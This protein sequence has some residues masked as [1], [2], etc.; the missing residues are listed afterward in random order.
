MSSR[1]NRMQFLKIFALATVLT[2]FAPPPADAQEF[3]SRQIHLARTTFLQPM[4]TAGAAPQNV[5]VNSRSNPE[6]MLS[7]DGTNAHDQRL[8]NGGQT[9]S[10]EPAQPGLCVGNGFAL[11]TT[12]GGVHIFDTRGNALTGVTDL[13]TF[14]G[15]P[16]AFSITNEYGPEVTDVSC[17]SDPDTQ[18]MF[19]L[20]LTLERVGTTSELSKI[21]HLDV[22]VS[23][24]PNP[25]G[26]WNIYK[27]PAQND[28]T[29]GTPNLHCVGGPCLA[30]FP[31]IGA[32]A[33]GIYI[34][35]NAFSFE[36]GF[37]NSKLHGAQ[38]YAISKR[39]LTSGQSAINVIEFDT[40]DPN[41]LLDGNPGFSIKA[42]TSPAA[43]YAKDL[44][45]TEYFLSSLAVVKLL[46]P[47]PPRKASDKRLRIWALSNTQS[48]DSDHPV[49]TLKHTVVDVQSYTTPAWYKQKKG[50]TPLRKCL[51]DSKL[52]TPNGVGCWRV[53]GFTAQPDH[54]RRSLIL[55]SDSRMQQVVF[56]DGKLWSALNT[57]LDFGNDTHAGVAYFV[58]RPSISN[59][60]L[61]GHVLTQGNL[62]LADNNLT[63]PAVGVTAKGKAVI[64]FTLFGADYFPSSAYAI[65]DA[66]SGAGEIHIA[67]AGLGPEDGFTGYIAFGGS[68]VA[69]WGDYSAAVPDG[70]SIWI[71][72]EYIGQTCEFAE[73]ATFPTGFGRCGESRIASINWGTRISKITPS[74][75]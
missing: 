45:G 49:L 28:G 24:T 23:Q 56:A 47:D 57:A 59:A 1:I 52:V 20:A 46:V 42:A 11:E 43:S 9:I 63:Y 25:L 26:G 60:A 41:L 61:G 54:E 40:A 6:L 44:G 68:S 16:P 7:F 22:A 32:D 67:A 62:G 17:Y 13:N 31:Q 39:A 10:T 2:V 75:R 74:S 66:N 37:L 34:T 55:S 50:P 19:V 58:I 48:L 15:Y 51:N 3:T 33:N 27:I 4:P 8:A 29:Q 73:Y 72:S 21:N 64:A 12:S 70:D 14:Y 35:T 65:L 18:R 69:R 38:I 30:D 5:A 53:F 36:P 71:A